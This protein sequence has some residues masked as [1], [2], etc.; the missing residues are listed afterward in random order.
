MKAFTQGIVTH[1]KI[2][3]LFVL[4]ILLPA[5]VVGYL[6][7]KT[8]SEKQKA[9]KSFLE[10]NLWI[11]GEAAL[12]AVEDELLDL[13]ESALKKEM[14]AG[15][16]QSDTPEER[17]S[18]FLKASVEI[19]GK[20]F[21]LDEN[22]EIVIPR[23]ARAEIVH[24]NWIRDLS[25]T[26]FS[27]ALKAAETLEFGQSNYSLALE[28]YSQ[29]LSMATLK[30]QKAYVLEAMGRCLLALKDYVK[31]HETYTKLATE[32]GQFLNRAGHPYGLTANLQMYEIGKHLDHKEKDLG[33]LVEILEKLNKGEY[34]ISLPAYE[35]FEKQI[36]AILDAE[37]KKDRFQE[38]KESYENFRSKG[39]SYLEILLFEDFI[40]RDVIPKMTERRS[41]A[42]FGGD[43][44]SGRFLA[45]ENE[46]YCLISYI[47]FPGFRDKR[48]FYG[49]ICWDLDAFRNDIFPRMLK[50]LEKDKGLHLS[51][52][53][54]KGWNVLTG[55]EEPASEKAVSLT[56]RQYP[57]P[58]KLVVTQPALDDVVRATRRDK[59]FYGVLLGFVVVLML[60]GAFLIARD[61]SREA[62]TMRLRT[63]FVHH[64][65]HELK[66]PLT[67]IRLY[68]ETLQ[69]K[70]DL[71]KPEQT[72]AYEI[73]T[74]E[75]ERLSHLINNVLDFSRIEM[76]KKEFVFKK[77][78]L[79]G[80]I[81]ETLESYRYHLEKK[82]FLVREEIADD[83]PEMTFDAEGVASVL[84]N[85]LSNAVKFSL[86]TKEVTIRLFME[87][88]HAVLQ[89]EDKGIGISSQEISRIFEK[90]YRSKDVKAADTKGSGL[91][92]TLVKHI[93]EAHGGQIKV[94]SEPGRGSTFIVILPISSPKQ[95]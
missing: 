5:L 1:K 83:I 39:S 48:P 38:T 25:D 79:A 33:T 81:R 19:K 36:Q 44:Q 90:F 72:E 60:F 67:L 84:I 16:L 69:R 55:T 51:M 47:T 11:S 53:D 85:L 27:R 23:T 92:L 73:I 75:S 3:L 29:C 40:K 59:V 89:V 91:G 50:D 30:H 20:P 54:G 71:S 41:L 7:F 76:G 8:F 31:A 65:S 18:E 17:L 15:L 34:L 42:R 4:A 95:G 26:P 77:G 21:L 82:G 74:K 62:D 37:F 64:V 12:K 10:S 61:I 66:T 45:P 24:D 94:Q 63:E 70:N 87:D 93:T 86:L 49:G 78:C 32:Y 14:F 22:F 6:S 28:G 57:L 52:I 46:N 9:V 88:N 2:I 58:W 68:G 43:A 80:V 13:E 35:F 56:F